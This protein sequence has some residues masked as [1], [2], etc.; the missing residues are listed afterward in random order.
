M[1]MHPD[2]V[3]ECLQKEMQLFS[4]FSEHNTPVVHIDLLWLYSKNSTIQAISM[5]TGLS[6]LNG[7][8]V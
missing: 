1:Q 7:A 3:D 6:F 4:P 2:V 5:I 8:S